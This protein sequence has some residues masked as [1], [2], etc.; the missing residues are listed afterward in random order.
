MLIIAAGTFAT[1]FSHVYWLTIVL[2]TCMSSG[3][4]CGS[5]I[6]ALAADLFPSQY[7]GM[8]LCLTMMTFRL[9]SVLGSFLIHAVAFQGEMWCTGLLLAFGAV[10]LRE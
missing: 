2:M 1:P 9:G 5:A 4:S 7:R 3:A 10:T 6:S 8:A